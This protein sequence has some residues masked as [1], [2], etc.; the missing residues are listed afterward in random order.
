MFFCLPFFLLCLL[1][2]INIG[3]AR[4]W[5]WKF[6]VDGVHAYIG[7]RGMAGW[8]MVVSCERSFVIFWCFHQVI[9]ISDTLTCS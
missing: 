7:W 3:Y 1:F 6:L 9:I 2:F 8:S 4:C 5:G